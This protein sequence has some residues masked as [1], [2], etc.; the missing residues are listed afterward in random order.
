MDDLPSP[1][2]PRL[3]SCLQQMVQAGAS[4]LFLVAGA[5]PTLKQQGQFVALGAAAI[6]APDVCAM[7]YSVMSVAQRAAF[8]ACM[9]CDLAYQTDRADRFRINVHRQ[10]GQVGMVVRYVSPVIPSLE[11]LGLPPVLKQLAFLK[12][13][14]VLAVGAA[15]AGKTTT[16][17]SLLDHRNE[18]TAGHILTIE[19]PIEYLHAHRKSLITQREVGIDTLSYDDALRHAMREAPDV[20]MIGEIRDRIT[21]Q[22]AL[23]YAESGHLCLSTLHANNASQAV[24]RILNFFPEEAHGQL[25]MDLA[26]NLKA[27][28]AQRLIAGRHKHKVP[29][30]EVMLQTHYVSELIQKGQIEGLRGAIER[31]GELG[32][33]TFDQSI[34]QLF[35]RGAIAQS[36]AVAHA[37]NKT[38]MALRMRLAAGASL[39]VEGMH[40]APDASAETTSP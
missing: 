23:H 37:D 18:H 34:F 1:V 22:H 30:V 20:I 24:Q 36:E 31:T 7:A 40:M 2:D 5:P 10:R 32:M 3:T 35:E 6:A 14:L 38:D 16:L 27:V 39:S 15:G 21:M 17:A 4:D 13:G 28:V 33:C 19:D 26:L 11:T 12:G 8:E 25:R 9:E 29:A